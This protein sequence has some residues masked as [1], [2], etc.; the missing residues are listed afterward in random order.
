[1][2]SKFTAVV[3]SRFIQLLEEKRS[4]N[5]RYLCLLFCVDEEAGYNLVL[6]GEAAPKFWNLMTFISEEWKPL[7][8]WGVS[9]IEGGTRPAQYWTLGLQPPA[10]T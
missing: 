8:A 10:V 9:Q 6:D 4:E 7:M 3:T 2:S 5:P 1:M